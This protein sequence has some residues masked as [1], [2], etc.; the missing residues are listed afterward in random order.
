MAKILSTFIPEKREYLSLGHN[1]DLYKGINYLL[2]Y[3]EAIE[4][5][6]KFSTSNIDG[7]EFHLQMISCYDSFYVSSYNTLTLEKI[8]SRLATRI[9]LETLFFERELKKIEQ[10]PSVLDHE[11]IYDVYHQH[12]S[13]Q[14]PLFDFME[15]NA[16]EEA[17]RFFLKNDA[18]M[19]MEF[20][21]YL[22]LTILGTQNIIKEEISRNLWDEAGYG[23]VEKFHTTIFHRLLKDLGIN[24]DRETLLSSMGWEG[25]AGLNL[26]YFLA[27][28]PQNKVR[29]F[30]AMAASELL[31]PLNYGKFA[32]GMSRIFGTKYNLSYY[33]EHEQ[34]DVAHAEG[35]INKV[36]LKT[37]EN[38]NDLKERNDFI[39]QFWQGFIMRLNSANLY[40]NN[41]LKSVL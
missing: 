20:F 34:M 31:D 26:F 25:L 4:C 9:L 24:Y 37:L 2:T 41:I 27:H 38:L 1:R 10:I 19:C 39:E 32:K 35:W 28:N 3:P 8:F 33:T 14:H 36:V 30:G 40:Y 6:K 12:A 15:H 7:K 22:I 16:N 5:A 21:D 17:I 23:D 29:L 13:S 11:S 18:I